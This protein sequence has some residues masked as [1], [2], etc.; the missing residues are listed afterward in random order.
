MIVKPQGLHHVTAI[1]GE[2][3][4]NVDFYVTG[5]GLRLVKK[6]VN[7]DDPGTYT[8]RL[9]ELSTEFKALEPQEPTLA[10]AHGDLS[11]QI[12]AVLNTVENPTI[13]GV[14]D[15]PTVVAE[16]QIALMDYVDACTPG[17]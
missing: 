11:A 2:P 4:K 12:D 13:S 7:F 15:L 3:Q 5:L 1:A 10:A 16:S 14:A 8:E 6:T 17:G 9:T